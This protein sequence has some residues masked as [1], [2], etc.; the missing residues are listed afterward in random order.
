MT[1][2]ELAA[3]LSGRQIGDEITDEECEQAKRDQ[4]V[5][6]FGYSDDNVE[7][8]GQWNDELGVGD[9]TE[10]EVDS[11]GPLMSWGA[12]EHDNEDECREYFRRKEHKRMTIKCEWCKGDYSW[13]YATA[14]SHATFDILEGEEKFC[15]GIVFSI[16][17]L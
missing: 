10:I 4:L 14:I 15:R 9:D 17:D 3:T 7:F 16:N 5:V 11:E 6:V 8:R 2:E 1:K 12:I 13:T